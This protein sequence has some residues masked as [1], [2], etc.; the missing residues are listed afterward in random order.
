MSPATGDPRVISVR[1]YLLH[2]RTGPEPAALP[3]GAVDREA[4]ELRKLPG[5]VLD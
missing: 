2:V 1:A 5:Q 4:A 3:R